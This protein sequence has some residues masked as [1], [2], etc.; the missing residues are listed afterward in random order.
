[1]KYRCMIKPVVWLVPNLLRG[2]VL[3]LMRRELQL[4]LVCGRFSDPQKWVKQN[5]LNWIVWIQSEVLYYLKIILDLK[6]WVV[7]FFF[8]Q[9]L[10]N[11]HNFALRK[12]KLQYTARQWLLPVLCSSFDLVGGGHK[13]E[14]LSDIHVGG[15]RFCILGIVVVKV[16]M[17]FCPNRAVDRDV[18]APWWSM[19]HGPRRA[20]LIPH[21]MYEVFVESTRP[22]GNYV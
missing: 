22:V 17:A 10:I 15:L 2:R 7:L 19:P 21:P 12:R 9:R 6:L 14:A 4:C 5:L 1:M 20:W 8:R 3:H 16:V 11:I 18:G 13:R